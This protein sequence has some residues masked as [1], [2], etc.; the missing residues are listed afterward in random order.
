MNVKDELNFLAAQVHEAN[1]KWWHDM[2]TGE[3]LDRNKGELLCL[4]HS[5]ISEAMEAER[6]DLMDDKLPH[7][8]GAEVEMA[9]ALIRILDY[10]AGHGYDIGGA[11]E[12]K[13]AYNAVRED[14]K[15]ESRKQ[16]HGKKW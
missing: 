13:M 12:E 7:R 5:E 3:R 15:I 1:H 10:C 2:D 6:K 11:F 8:K 9:D 4:V 14:H 16:A